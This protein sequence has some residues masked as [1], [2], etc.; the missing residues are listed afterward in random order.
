MAPAPATSSSAAESGAAPPQRCSVVAGSSATLPTRCLGATGSGAIPPDR[1]SGA[2]GYG[3]TPHQRRTSSPPHP[4]RATP[5]FGPIPPPHGGGQFRRLLFWRHPLFG[6]ARHAKRFLHDG[7]WITRA[8]G[9][10]SIFFLISSSCSLCLMHANISCNEF[11]LEWWIFVRK[12]CG[13]ISSILL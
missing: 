8:C 6:T 11:S 5:P 13:S 9:L 2:A 12:I 4:P 10:T 1:C 3:A 7:G